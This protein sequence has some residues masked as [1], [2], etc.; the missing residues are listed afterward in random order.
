MHLF[1]VRLKCLLRDRTILFWTLF[2]PIILAT[3]FNFTLAKAN[4][5]LEI[6]I[7]KK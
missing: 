3:F 5:D 1:K 7:I 6:S 4:Y 2:F